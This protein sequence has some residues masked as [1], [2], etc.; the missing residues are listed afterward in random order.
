M[1]LTKLQSQILRSL[2]AHRSPESFVAGSIPLNRDR[3]RYSGDIDIF[4]DIP[5]RM[6]PIVAAD[7]DILRSAGYVVTLS[8]P[9][10]LYIQRGVIAS[11]GETTEIDWVIDS[12]FRFF[13]AVPDELFGY[14]LHPVDLAVNKA[15]AAS[16]RRVPR[17]IVDLIA[18]D[19]DILP[20]GAVLCAAVGRF[21]G[22]TPEG[23]LEDISR[24]SNFTP[25][26]YADLKME[27]P[28]DIADTHKKIRS[29]IERARDFVPRMPSDALGAVFL[30]D[31]VP[32]QPDPTRLGDYVRHEGARRGH[33]PSSSEIGSA[34]L[35][36]YGQRDTEEPE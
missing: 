27:R 22:P 17:D 4:N 6:A 26:E 25:P 36:R 32:V 7:V 19:A 18:I 5:E 8:E 30:K 10:N 9:R 20:L 12:D 31:G 35:E 3:A 24:R 33:W 21:P 23:M 1:P 14:A 16:S 29:M 13:P 15:S 34:M 28:L 11:G 2:A